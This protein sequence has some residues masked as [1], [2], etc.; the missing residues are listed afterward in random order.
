MKI[1][2]ADDGTFCLVR[3]QDGKIMQVGMSKTQL[4]TLQL[5]L[6]A[7]SKDDPFIVMGDDHEL[8][9]KK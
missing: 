9:L 1:S 2:V 4:S 8:V 5:F 6:T 3:V 7:L